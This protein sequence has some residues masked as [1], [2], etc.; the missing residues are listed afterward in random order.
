MQHP[1]VG[2]LETDLWDK[3]GD[4]NFF[5]TMELIPGCLHILLDVLCG[6]SKFQA[7]S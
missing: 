6:I 1:F 2:I 4:S 3:N 7:G 5:Y